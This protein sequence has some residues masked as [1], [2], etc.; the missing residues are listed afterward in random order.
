MRRHPAVKDCAVIGLPDP[1]WG[2]SI[3]C[4]LQLEA[5]VDDSELVDHCRRFLAQYKTPRRWS[6]VASLPLNA[7]GK[8][9]KPALRL[10]QAN[11]GQ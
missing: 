6:R 2:E 8:V 1:R 11:P 7:A 4:V 10:A 3:C 9:D 5:E